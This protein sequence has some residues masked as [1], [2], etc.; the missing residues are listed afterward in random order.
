MTLTTT[1]FTRREKL[2]LLVT[3]LASA[4]AFIDGTVVNM[5]LAD[6][7]RSFTTDLAGLQW[8]VEAYILTLTAGLLAGGAAGDRWGR[9]RLL[10][11]GTSLFALASIACGFA[12]STGTL[13]AARMLQGVGA[14]LLIPGSLAVITATFGP[15]RRGHAIGLWSAGSALAV[16]AAPLLG[17]VLVE[18]AGWRWI[19]FINIP[20]AAAVLWVG[21]RTLTESRANPPPALDY[22]GTALVTAGLALAVFGMIEGTRFG[23]GAAIAAVPMSA[24]AGLLVIFLI[25]QSRAPSPLVPLTLLADRTYAAVS[26]ITVCLYA[27]LGAVTFF[28]PL[29]LITVLEWRESQAGLAMLPFIVPMATLSSRVGSLADKIGPKPL[30]AVGSILTGVGWGS[31]GFA[32]S[33][34]TGWH[35]IIGAMCIVGAGMT[36]AVA[37]LT[38]AVMNAA[39]PGRTGM[40]SALN[41]AISRLAMLIAIAL[42]G[43]LAVAAFLGALP[44]E[45]AL[46][47]V[48]EEAAKLAAATLPPEAAPDL[49]KLAAG[50]AFQAVVAASGLLCLCSGLLAALLMRGKAPTPDR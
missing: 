24:G 4:M 1:D 44:E 25:W 5:A 48:R 32:A 43:T 12:P 9:K 38:T 23:F 15:E 47:T 33:P 29:H 17:G 27:A 35:W 37:P 30:L 36:L 14:A 46:Q 20:I 8:V 40:A 7:Q 41:N 2:V 19:F 34:G 45:I 50:S 13:T 16:A 49:A 21:G 11:W 31:L 28:L 10:L 39:P 22:P 18:W 26:G 3:I 42:A 6:L